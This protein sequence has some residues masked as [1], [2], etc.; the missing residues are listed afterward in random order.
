MLLRTGRNVYSIPSHLRFLNGT[1]TLNSNVLREV[2]FKGKLSIS[3][4][5]LST[6]LKNRTQRATVAEALRDHVKTRRY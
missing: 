6:A 3:L 1:Y 4:N 2:L 5:G